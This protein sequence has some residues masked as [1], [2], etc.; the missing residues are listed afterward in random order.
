M[1][2]DRKSIF[3]ACALICLMLLCGA[4]RRSLPKEHCNALPPIYPDYANVTVPC[5]I[6]PLNFMVR[7]AKAVTASV[8]GADGRVLLT[9]SGS[10]RISIPEGKW[11]KLLANHQ[12][13][14]LRVQVAAWTTEH[15]EGMAYAPFVINVGDSIDSYVVYR[16]INVPTKLWNKMGIFQ[17][18]LED[19]TEESLV[20]NSQNKNGCINCHSFRQ[21]N[22][23][24][25]LFHARGK[26]SGTVFFKDG[27]V[28]M[29]H[30]NRLPPRKGVACSAWHNSGRWVAFSSNHFDTVFYSHCNK[31]SDVFEYASDLLIY[32]VQNNKMI[33]DVRFND[34]IR[35]ETFPT[36]SPDGKMLYFCSSASHKL[37]W[38]VEQ[39]HYDILR[40]PF[41]AAT[42]KIGV[43][44]DTV[45]NAVADEGSA[46][47]PRISPDGRWLLFV[48]S[49]FGTFS[50]YYPHADMRLIDLQA[51]T[52]RAEKCVPLGEHCSYHHWSSNGKWVIFSAKYDDALTR[53]YIVSFQDGKWG[54]P[55]LLPQKNPKHNL[56]RHWCY[57]IP[58]LVKSKVELDKEV[59]ERVMLK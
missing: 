28:T 55:F 46:S 24:Q 16:L 56:H 1:I 32:D 53:L 57:N 58:E 18:C 41:D 21:N 42:G 10:E 49:H 20:Q 50:I 3:T 39:M 17:R 13:K 26:L 43:H 48:R 22:P 27:K 4:C 33:E 8:M 51:D 6:A 5:N 2:Y 37:P 31:S 25:W 34:T 11:H 29:T 9:L 45:Y 19:F 36:F 38:E 35:M 54:K 52:L 12:G 59:L 15:P 23:D 7:G 47:L 14:S 30:P 40:A 44:V